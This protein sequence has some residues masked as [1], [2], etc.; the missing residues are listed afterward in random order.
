MFEHIRLFYGLARLTVKRRN[1]GFAAAQVRLATYP[2]PVIL[3]KIHAKLCKKQ[4]ILDIF[5]VP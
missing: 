3:G 4:S 1:V 2:L 5:G